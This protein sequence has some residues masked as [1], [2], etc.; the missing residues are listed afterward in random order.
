[1]INGD[2][3]MLLHGG[4]FFCEKGFEDFGVKDFRSNKARQWLYNGHSM[5]IQWSDSCQTVVI[6]LSDND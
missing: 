1:M 3:K 6:Q 4:G 2:N 5:V